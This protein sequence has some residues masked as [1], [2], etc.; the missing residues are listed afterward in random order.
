MLQLLGI[1]AP[2]LQAQTDLLS[3]MGQKRKALIRK[4]PCTGRLG[5]GGHTCAYRWPLARALPA[6]SQRKRQ[7]E[8]SAGLVRAAGTSQQRGHSCA[9]GRLWCER[10]GTHCRW[11]HARPR[12]TGTMRSRGPARSRQ[13]DGGPIPPACLAQEHA[14]SPGRLVAGAAAAAGQ[15]SQA[16][17]LASFKFK[18][19]KQS[20]CS[21]L[22]VLSCPG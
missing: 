14:A 11:H 1:H 15:H 9:A 6:P 7:G 16:Q 19:R 17:L 22:C 10:V 13:E 4:A 20:R 12:H 3:N 5:A 18:G 21:W 2:C 8:M